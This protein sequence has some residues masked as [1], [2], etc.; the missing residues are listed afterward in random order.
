MALF[1]AGLREQVHPLGITKAALGEGRERSQ[2][3]GAF[4][5]T[6][7]WELVKCRFL[8]HTPF[9]H[10]HGVALLWYQKICIPP[11]PLFWPPCGIWSSWDQGSDL[12]QQL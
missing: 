7:L 10:S 9:R 5:S 6:D 1:G 11:S 4:S 8:G 2:C 3:S 12:S